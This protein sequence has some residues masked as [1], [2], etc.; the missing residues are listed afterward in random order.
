MRSPSTERG[1]VYAARDERIITYLL[2]GSTSRHIAVLEGL[3][4]DRCRKLCR[5]LVEEHELVLPAP[6]QR[7]SPA[8]VTLPVG[9]TDAS[10]GLRNR[11]GDELYG[12]VEFLQ[13]RRLRLAEVGVLTGLPPSA[14]KRAST[15]PYAH[16]WTLGQIE[17][18]L[19]A[20]KHKEDFTL[21]MLRMLLPPLGTATQ[22][23]KRAAIGL[24]LSPEESR[25]VADSLG[26]L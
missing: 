24:L 15:R 25:R 20:Y 16:D 22:A 26:W 13:G 18:L 5:A 9:V 8:P 17:R 10:R 23:L 14:Q 6:P 1:A 12:L 3:D 11:L 7:G 2:N 4:E 21:F 19:A